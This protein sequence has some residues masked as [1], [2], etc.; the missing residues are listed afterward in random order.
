[1]SHVEIKSLRK[2]YAGFTAV[3]DLSVR[4]EKGEFVSILGPSGCGKTTTLNMLAGFTEPTSG[5]ILVNGASVVGVPPHRRSVGIVFQNYAL[6]PH[7]DVFENVA[8]GLRMRKLP[9]TLLREKVQHALSLVHLSQMS[10]RLIPELSGGQQQRVALARALVIEPDLLLLDEPL[11]NLDANLRERMRDEIREIQ[12]RIG[13]TTIFVT[14]DQ[15]EAMATSDR[16]MVMSAGHLQQFG[17]PQQIYHEPQN[18]FVARFIGKANILPVQVAAAS[19][20]GTELRT[21]DG[22]SLHLSPRAVTPGTAAQLVLR[23][24]NLGHGPRGGLQAVVRR[25]TFLGPVWEISAQLGQTEL[26]LRVGSA[27]QPPAPG[28]GIRVTFDPADGYLLPVS[29]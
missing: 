25:V 1:M 8:F 26:I 24:E 20:A 19:A 7:L 12:Q 5:D 15:S 23:P 13:I 11:S 9:T 16:V 6:F 17:T 18:D 14:H 22:Q 3:H 27:A 29:A 2:A 21:E 28:T 4:I 10:G